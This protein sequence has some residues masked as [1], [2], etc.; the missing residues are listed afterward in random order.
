MISAAG[1]SSA[2]TLSAVRRWLRQL[3][4]E[5][6]RNRSAVNLVPSENRLSPAAQRQRATDF[7]NPLAEEAETVVAVLTA[8]VGR[9]A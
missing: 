4:I 2:S 1:A 5:D 3:E 9:I 7:Y 6:S 8:A